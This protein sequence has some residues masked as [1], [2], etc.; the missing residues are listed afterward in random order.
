MEMLTGNGQPP[1]HLKGQLGQHYK[2]LKTGDM[3][4]LV[5]ANE[6]STIHHAPVRGYIWKRVARGDH[7]EVCAGGSGE[8]GGGVTSWNDLTDKPFYKETNTVQFADSQSIEFATA[9][10]PAIDA[11]P[12]ELIE[13]ET[14][15]ITWD[16]VAYNCVAYI[17]ADGV[18]PVAGNAGLVGMDGGNGEPF[19]IAVENGSSLV[20]AQETGTHTV[21]ME[22]HKVIYH[23]IDSSYLP[24]V[25]TLKCFIATV[26]NGKYKC[27][28]TF[29]ELYETIN[30]GMPCIA[31]IYDTMNLVSYTSMAITLFNEYITIYTRNGMGNVTF[32]Y[33]R[34]GRFGFEDG[35]GDA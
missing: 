2:D 14:Y 16:G 22:G 18:P 20:F 26:D 28:M 30:S 10:Q 25:C 17:P 27:N 7:M 6:F 23:K 11:F 1:K 12:V 19:F 15:K 13:N 8:G 34:D 3:Y 31:T 9:G 29:D 35:F 24:T 21:S 5:S 4:E 32:M 33:M